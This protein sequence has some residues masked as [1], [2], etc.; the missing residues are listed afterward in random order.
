M[1]R[2]QFELNPALQFCEEQCLMASAMMPPSSSALYRV[3]GKLLL[4]TS[5]AQLHQP[6][7][8]I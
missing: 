5:K 6:G 3:Q 4:K 1:P 7:M 2:P 8:P